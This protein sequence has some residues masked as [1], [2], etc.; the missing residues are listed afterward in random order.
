VRTRSAS[1]MSLGLVL[2]GLSNQKDGADTERLA[3][4]GGGTVQSLLD[5]G[6]ALWSG[7][8]LGYFT[9]ECIHGIRYEKSAKVTTSRPAER[10]VKFSKFVVKSVGSVGVIMYSS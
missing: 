4:E 6:P 8:V 1:R 7:V 2:G 9:V 10:W 5:G 3:D